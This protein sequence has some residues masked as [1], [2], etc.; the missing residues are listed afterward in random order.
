[1]SPSRV[2][3]LDHRRSGPYES[4]ESRTVV[5]FTVDPQFAAILAPMAEA[6]AAAPRPAVG[7]VATRHVA[8]EAMMAD[9]AELQPVARSA[10]ACVSSVPS[11]RPLRTR[12]LSNGANR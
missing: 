8:L 10:T 11:D 3:G 2:S 1:M 5:T 4:P 6:M 12:P 9:T 7:D